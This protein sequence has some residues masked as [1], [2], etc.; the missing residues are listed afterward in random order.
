MT[1]LKNKRVKWKIIIPVLS[2]L[3]VAVIA[4]FALLAIFRE[5]ETHVVSLGTAG[6][7]EDA[8]HY[9]LATYKYEFLR[10]YKEEGLRDNGASWRSLSSDGEH[11]WEKLF[12]LE[13][14]DYLARKIAAAAI[15]DASYS[16]SATSR[17]EINAKFK[18]VLA[19]NG[20]KKAVNEALSLYSCDSE[21]LRR[22]MTLDYKGAMLYSILYG[23]NGSGLPEGLL[24]ETYQKEFAH[25]QTVFIRTAGKINSDGTKTELTATEQEEAERKIATLQAYLEDG[26]TEAEILSLQAQ[27]NEDEIAAK[28]PNGIYLSEIGVHDEKV[29]EQALSL[30]VGE[31][32]LVQ[33][34]YGA[35]LIYRLSNP[36][37]AYAQEANAEWFRGF[38]QTV[39]EREYGKLIEGVLSDVRFEEDLFY[40]DLVILTPKNYEIVY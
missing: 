19:E 15:F 8:F 38:T 32:A 24:E 14:S 18:S 29:I 34:E 30:K 2:L 3:L 25:V 16:L 10:E 9:Y 12:Y 37:G 31:G 17:G 21:D 20:G 11:T 22:A 36:V 35:Y 39:A 6:V 1:I 7:S 26:M 40:D 33:G 27:F 4:V 5:E 23:T 28:Y 13:F